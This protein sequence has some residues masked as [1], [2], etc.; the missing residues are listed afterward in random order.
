MALTVMP[1]A[2]P[3]SAAVRVRPISPCFAATYA[4]LNGEATRPWMEPML[5]T[6]PQCCAFIAGHAYLVRRKGAVSITA[7]TAS[8]FSSGKSSMGSMC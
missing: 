5:M 1:C 3:S 7:R 4:H 8:H 2:P 6:R